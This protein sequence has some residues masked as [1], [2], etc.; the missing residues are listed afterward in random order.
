MMT[1][2]MIAAGVLGLGGGSV[3]V[4]WVA[5]LLITRYIKE[6]DT[7]HNQ[8]GKAIGKLG[9][10]QRSV[11]KELGNAQNLIY[12]E[13]SSK[14]SEIVTDIAV[15][16]S[17]MGEVM[18]VRDDV[19]ENS[20]AVAIALERITQNAEDIDHGFASV[21]KQLMRTEDKISELQKTGS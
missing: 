13:L 9:E 11:Y 7:R 10:A 1:P 19:K 2:E 12:Q 6:N 20:R 18:N 17:R 8:A 14:L 4:G 16:K 5:K 3:S 21:R 15:I